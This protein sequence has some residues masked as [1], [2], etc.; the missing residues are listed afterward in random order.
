V[1][2][3]LNCLSCKCAVD[4][5]EAKFFAAL[6]LCPD[7]FTIAERLYRRG[8]AELRMMLTVLKESIRLAALKGELQFSL[9]NLDDMKKEDL[10]G[11]LANLAV[12]AR[13]EV[14]QVKE[15]SKPWNKTPSLDPT[16]PPALSAAG[17]P[18]SSSTSE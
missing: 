11:H 15:Q 14:E 10:I 7:C 9:Q 6:F 16:L 4:T 13:K 1:V 18:S 17:K 8:E 2:G 12:E 3:V 5:D